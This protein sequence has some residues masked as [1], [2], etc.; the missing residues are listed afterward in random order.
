VYDRRFVALVFLV[1][2]PFYFGATVVS[3]GLLANAG[4]W[5]SVTAVRL[6]GG[7]ILISCSSIAS[8]LVY[9]RG[10][11]WPFA[12]CMVKGFICNTGSFFVAIFLFSVVLPA[13]NAKVQ[14]VVY[15][16]DR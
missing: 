12:W 3:H 8:W 10:T 14:Q 13:Y 15:N 11:P 5:K 2:A 9:R 7:P 4:S 1:A 16:P 6:L